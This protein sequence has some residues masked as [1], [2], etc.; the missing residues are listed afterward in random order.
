MENNK[1]V[2]KMSF[3]KGLKVSFDSIVDNFFIFTFLSLFCSFFISLANYVFVA[4]GMTNPVILLS[5]IFAF[6]LFTSFFVNNWYNVIEHKDVSI[7]S[8]FINFSFKDTLRTSTFL[9][10]NCLAWSVVVGISFYLYN[11]DATTT[12]TH[13]FFIFFMLSLIV[14][15]CLLFLLN[16]V[17]FICFLRKEKWFVFS[18]VFLP[19][20]DN[21]NKIMGWTFVLLIMF[22]I[23]L[24]EVSVS[25][26]Y[27]IPNFLVT[28]LFIWVFYFCLAFYISILNY[29]YEK[30]L[31]EKTNN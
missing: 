23:L 27:D 1:N 8:I 14:I 21:V 18:K 3:F 9:F 10:F 20:Y 28:G 30:I 29:Q 25:S 7:K 19:T 31:V 5:F 17:V 2:V 13:E 11:K 24:N 4:Y 26:M 22:F 16:F 12:L 6:F 15:L